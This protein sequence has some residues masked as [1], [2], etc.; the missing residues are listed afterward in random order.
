MIKTKRVYQKY[1]ISDGLH[2]L[3]DRL[4]PRGVRKSTPNVELWF[5]DVAPSDELRK[6]YGHDP[7][8]WKTFKQLY[9]KELMKNEAAVNQL[10]EI[11][12]EN[13]PITLI[14]AASDTERNNAVLLKS[15]LERKLKRLKGLRRR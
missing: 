6:R 14:Y 12:R 8:K 13:N 7:K 4:W 5:R 9:L 10:V 15:F 3:V 1:D 11:A 2:I